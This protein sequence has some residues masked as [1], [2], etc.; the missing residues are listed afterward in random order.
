M[1]G[2]RDGVAA[3]RALVQPPVTSAPPAAGSPGLRG[4]PGTAVGEG[5]TRSQESQGLFINHAAKEPCPG[6]PFLTCVSSCYRKL[7]ADF[8]PD[9]HILRRREGKSQAIC[10]GPCSGGEGCTR[11]FPRQSPG[12]TQGQTFR[13]TWLFDFFN[14]V[15]DP[16][17]L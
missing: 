1:P 14:A 6:S 8:T 17:V 11:R 13:L 15:L 3:S 7:R 9:L 10:S 5:W 2:H 12:A 16:D 4:K